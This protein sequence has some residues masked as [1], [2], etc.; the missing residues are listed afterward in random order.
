MET[1]LVQDFEI[2][3]FFLQLSNLQRLHGVFFVLKIAINP[4][5]EILNDLYGKKDKK[6]IFHGYIVHDQYNLQE[7]IGN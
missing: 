7:N 1:Y 6:I 4:A 5:T 2:I 3:Y